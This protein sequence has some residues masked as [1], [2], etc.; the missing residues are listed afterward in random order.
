MGAMSVG[1][2]EFQLADGLAEW[3][4]DW[5]AALLDKMTDRMLAVQMVDLMAH[6]MAG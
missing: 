2:L 5:K 6:W 1:S 3:K 4:D